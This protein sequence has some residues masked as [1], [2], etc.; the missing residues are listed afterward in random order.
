MKVLLTAWLTWWRSLW[1]A[2][3][4]KWALPPVRQ[5][6]KLSLEQQVRRGSEARSIWDHPV[7]A[8]AVQRVQDALAVSRQRVPWSDQTMHTRIILAEQ[9][10]T[11]LLGHL[12]EV[13]TTGELARHDILKAQST[14][15]RMSQAFRRGLRA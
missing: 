6:G 9:T 1:L 13:M 8:E 10:F 14:A 3:P 4:P 7:F 15:E 12:Q 11:Q 2:P 5:V